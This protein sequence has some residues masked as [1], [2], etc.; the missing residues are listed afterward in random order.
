MV[1]CLKEVWSSVCLLFANEDGPGSSQQGVTWSN[2]GCLCCQ[3]TLLAHVQFA[4]QQDFQTKQQSSSLGSVTAGSS[5]FP[6]AYICGFL[7][8]LFS[9]CPIPPACLGPSECWPCSWVYWLILPPTPDW[10]HERG[11]SIIFSRLFTRM[12][13]RTGPSTDLVLLH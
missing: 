5:S 11:H 12:L 3:A 4:V 1:H 8:S 2:V 9:H 10:C 7:Q 13:N 6:G